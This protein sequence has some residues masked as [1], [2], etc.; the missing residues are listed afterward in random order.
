[1]RTTA[2]KIDAGQLRDLVEV[3]RLDQVEQGYLWTPIGSIRAEATLSDKSNY[4][5]RSG[6]GARDV[7]F[8]L[9]HRPALSLDNAL[10]WRGPQGWEH[11]MITSITPIDRL[12][13]SVRCARVRLRDCLAE[14]NHTPP[15]PRFPGVLA[16]KYVR[17]EQLDPLAVNI[18]TYVLVT[19]K[20]VEL[21][22]GSIVTVDGVAYEV[23]VGH[24]LDEWKNEFEIMKV[25]DL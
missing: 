13:D 18:I 3:L 9:R 12:Y 25:V 1:M 4:F 5:A 16:E 11:C 19:P 6:V 8:V 20:A 17:H 23:Q 2:Q 14:A 7:G 10:R 22:R 24:L 15:G 21:K